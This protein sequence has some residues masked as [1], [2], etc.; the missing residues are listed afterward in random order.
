M[1][2]LP[3][4]GSVIIT[5]DRLVSAVGTVLFHYLGLIL[6]LGLER[7]QARHPTSNNIGLFRVPIR[8]PILILVC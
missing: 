7:Y 8:I 1:Q 4:S 3:I 5:V 2:P 6:K